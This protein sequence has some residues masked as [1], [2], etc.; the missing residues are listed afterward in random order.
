[1]LHARSV[2]ISGLRRV[3][4]TLKQGRGSRLSGEGLSARFERSIASIGGDHEAEART[5]S[6]R[7]LRILTPRAQER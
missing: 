2:R 3:T 1:M 5:W 4:K 7:R 6:S